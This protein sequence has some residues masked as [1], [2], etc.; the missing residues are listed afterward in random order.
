MQL[1]PRLLPPPSTGQIGQGGR[2]HGGGDGR[3]TGG[4]GP[5]PATSQG[6]PAVLQEGERGLQRCSC[7]P[8]LCTTL[9]VPAGADN[10]RESS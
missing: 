4:R 7:P 3:A 2:H 9:A 1:V 10:A 6:A 8:A 5:F